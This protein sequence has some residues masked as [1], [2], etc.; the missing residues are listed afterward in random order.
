M[1][2]TKTLTKVVKRDG[3]EEQFDSQKITQAI[4]KAGQAT[5][6]FEG[7]VAQ[8]LTHRVLNLIHGYIYN[9]HPTV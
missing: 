3:R 2:K 1:P 9:N 4:L 8:K 5:G 6:E 7:N